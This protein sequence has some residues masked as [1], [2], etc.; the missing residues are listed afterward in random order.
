MDLLSLIIEHLFGRRY[1]ANIV[2]HIGSRR[3]DISSYIFTTTKAARE[4]RDRLKDNRSFRF[5]QTISFR[6][7]EPLINIFPYV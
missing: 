6:S 4:H 2:Y 7:K 5:I 3:Y 1:Y